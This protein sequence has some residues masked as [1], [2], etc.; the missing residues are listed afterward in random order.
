MGVSHNFKG[1]T[2]SPPSPNFWR[3]FS[4]YNY[5]FRHDKYHL[6]TKDS[7]VYARTRLYGSVCLVITIAAWL[8]ESA[9]YSLLVF[10]MRAAYGGL[11]MRALY[12][13]ASTAAQY[14]R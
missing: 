7:R 3:P 10:L 12:H 9:G 1:G 2:A 5:S 6:K 14:N 13:I 11:S 8:I 4:V